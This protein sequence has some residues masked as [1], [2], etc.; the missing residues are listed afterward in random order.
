MA[1]TFYKK[2][3]PKTSPQPTWI[4]NSPLDEQF[5]QADSYCLESQI[6]ML[7][8]HA[9]IPLAYTFFE[10]H[11]LQASYLFVNSEEYLGAKSV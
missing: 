11:F 4:G 5:S 6:K 7:L 10:T 8:L 9:A 3:L 2:T 1:I